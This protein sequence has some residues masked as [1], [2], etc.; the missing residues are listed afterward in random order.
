MQA[1]PPRLH[2]Q[3]PPS[4]PH[5]H[6]ILGASPPNQEEAKAPEGS[7]CP[8]KRPQPRP[9]P[10]EPLLLGE[11]GTWEVNSLIKTVQ[12][13]NFAEWQFGGKKKKTQQWEN[14]GYAALDI[15]FSGDQL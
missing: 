8:S 1:P 13:P 11:F 3:L 14:V 4:P 9:R 15:Q 7:G 12:N 5:S 10:L 6:Q 2:H